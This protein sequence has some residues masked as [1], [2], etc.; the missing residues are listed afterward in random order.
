MQSTRTKQQQQQ[1]SHK[2]KEQ[3]KPKKMF[4]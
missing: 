2:V 3:E 4:V 1:L